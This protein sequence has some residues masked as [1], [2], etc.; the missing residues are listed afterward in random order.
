M[1]ALYNFFIRKNRENRA[2]S[3]IFGSIIIL[4][5]IGIIMIFSSSYYVAVARFNRGIFHFTLQQSRAVFIGVV[6]MFCASFFDYRKLKIPILLGYVLACGL[7][8]YVW[9]FGEDIS[10]VRR[11]IEIGPL[12]GFQPSEFAAVMVVL[13]L[14]LYLSSEKNDSYIDGKPAL[15]AVKLIRLLIALSIIAIPTFLVMQGGNVAAVLILATVGCIIIFVSSKHFIPYIGVAGLASAI[16]FFLVREVIFV[17]EGGGMHGD[18]FR[19]WRDLYAYQD[20]IGHQTIQSLYAVASGGWFGLGLGQSNQK[21]LILPE[22]YN[23]FIFAILIEEA[24]LFGALI[25]LVLFGVIIWRGLSVARRS[26]NMFGA[27]IATGAVTLIAVQVLIN[28]AVVLNIIPNTG[29]PMPFISYGGTSVVFNL[30]LMGILLNVSRFAKNEPTKLLTKDT[31]TRA[32][33][34]EG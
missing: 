32:V 11:W 15:A 16:G 3:I 8:V 12:P 23:D 31:K 22:A 13:M 27:L 33:K 1:R 7:L 6:I 24:G 10:N 2:D 21:Q 34:S 9:R 19:A 17:Q 26:P 28:V 4:V 29:S 30:A 14:S 25:V 20:T 5:M 18:R